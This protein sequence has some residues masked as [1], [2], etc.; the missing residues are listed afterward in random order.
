[1]DAA[2]TDGAIKHVMSGV[3]YIG[4]SFPV[5]S[6]TREVAE[7]PEYRH[8]V[9]GHPPLCDLPPSMRNTAPKSNCALR[10]EGGNGPIGPCCV[11]SYVVHAATRF[12]SATR[13]LI[14]WTES[15]E[16]AV[17]YLRNSL[18]CSRLRAST[19]GVA[20]QWRTTSS[21]MRSSNA[22]GRRLFRALKKRRI[23]ERAADG[24]DAGAALRLGATFDPAFLSRTGIRGT[25]DDPA[26]ASRWYRRVTSAT[27]PPK[28]NCKI[29]NSRGSRAWFAPA[30]RSRIANI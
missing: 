9:P 22:S 7:C 17:S 20:S 16:T 8:V 4:W 26:Q 12:P 21:A 15:G 29:S 24:G 27:P 2:G 19:P 11:P 10:P 6:V 23:A 18:T 28:N 25:S 14:V 3:S 1:M 13:S 30:L 5:F